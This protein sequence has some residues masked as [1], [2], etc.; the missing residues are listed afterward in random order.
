MHCQME[1]QR[2]AKPSWV[3]KASLEQFPVVGDNWQWIPLL[4]TDNQG[5]EP[6]EPRENTRRNQ[7]NCDWV[8]PQRAMDAHSVPFSPEWNAPHL[9]RRT[10]AFGRSRTAAEQDRSNAVSGG[11][12]AH[13]LMI[14]LDSLLHPSSGVHPERLSLVLPW[15]LGW[16]GAPSQR[17]ICVALERL[18]PDQMNGNPHRYRQQDELAP[19][20]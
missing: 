15:L 16:D 5:R 10:F 8:L 6:A 14:R 7:A 12:T 19:P 4:R 11:H 20:G 3:G 13:K 1:C 18:Y 17:R 2:K 9:R